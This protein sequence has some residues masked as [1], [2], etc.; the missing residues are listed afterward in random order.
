MHNKKS[1]D[2]KMFKLKML[3]VLRDLYSLYKILNDDD[4]IPQWCKDKLAKCQ[5]NMSSVSDYIISKNQKSK[6]DKH[7]KN[8]TDDI[9]N[10][11]KESIKKKSIAGSYPEESYQDKWHTM[12]EESFDKKD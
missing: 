1:N 2:G 6:I 11:V 9:K 4:N 3:T 7:D 8:T 5:D 12:P 10:Y